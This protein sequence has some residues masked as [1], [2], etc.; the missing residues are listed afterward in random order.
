MQKMKFLTL[1]STKQ[2]REREREREGEK[3][4]SKNI[5]NFKI[6]VAFSIILLPIFSSGNFKGILSFK[7]HLKRQ[8]VIC[9]FYI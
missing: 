1:P 7:E 8:S 3:E 5:S 9:L 2:E 6:D 4:R